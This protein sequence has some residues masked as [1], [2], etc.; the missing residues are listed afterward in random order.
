MASNG[1][2][3]LTTNG[4][5]DEV[6]EFPQAISET[7]IQA[8][9]VMVQENS[10]HLIEMTLGRFFHAAWYRPRI[11]GR[12]YFS[13]AAL[14][15]LVDRDGDLNECLMH[16]SPRK[17]DI[18][19]IW[20]MRRFVEITFFRRWKNI[21]DVYIEKK[22]TSDRIGTTFMKCVE[23]RLPVDGQL[24]RELDQITAR[25]G[26]EL[27]PNSS[28]MRFPDQSSNRNVRK[29]SDKKKV[30]FDDFLVQGLQRDWSREV[31]KQE[32]KERRRRAQER[33]RGPENH[34]QDE[35][36]IETDEKTGN[37]K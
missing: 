32:K 11:A 8:S 26:V 6:G 36:N 33:A 7:F 30:D 34:L 10:G 20:E 31:K 17:Q 18:L 19:P 15:V 37:D 27:L 28:D 21:F 12:V 25:E 3:N 2:N 13:L 16:D 24:T 35:G 1:T 5:A 4:T 14:R 23:D 9:A 22:F 29:R